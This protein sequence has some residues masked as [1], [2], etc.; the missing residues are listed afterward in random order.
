MGIEPEALRR[1]RRLLANSNGVVLAVGPTGS[2][3]TTLL[4]GMLNE[5]HSEERKLCSVEDPVEYL[6]DGVT[7]IRVNPAAG[8][9]FAAAGRTLMRM[10][11]DVIMIGELRDG[12][13][14][15]IVA[16]AAL[17]GHLVL[18]QLHTNNASDAV[19]RLVDIGL[20]PFIVESALRGVVAQRLVRRLCPDCKKEAASGACEELGLEAGKYFGPAGCD[21]C[22]G[23]GYKGRMPVYEFFEF[24]EKTRRL[25]SAGCSAEAFRAAALEE[26]LEPLTRYAG[27]LVAKGLTSV[28]EAGR[29]LAGL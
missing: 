6:I 3:K 16:N 26:G 8:M 23:S 14:A 2:G 13:S 25:L 24:G 10:D 18:S 29:V 12:E 21:K 15:Q 7:Q 17:T 28:E 19:C 9:T 4:Y 27:R 20:E 22:H 5:L 1:I 11:P